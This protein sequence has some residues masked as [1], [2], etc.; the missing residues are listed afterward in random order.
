VAEEERKAQAAL[1]QVQVLVQEELA[2]VAAEVDMAQA[3]AVKAAT[4]VTSAQV[5]KVYST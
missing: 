4:L 1:V 3:A 5:H 2:R